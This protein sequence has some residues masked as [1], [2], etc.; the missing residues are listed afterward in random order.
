M[1]FKKSLNQKFFKNW[2]FKMS[3]VL[4]YIIADGCIT[5]SKDRKNNPFTLNI[6]STEKKQLYRIK[7]ALK[8]GHKISKKPTG[9]PGAIGY[10]LQIRNLIL[11]KDLMDLGVFPRKTQNLNYIKV[12]RAYFSDF[13]RGFFDGDGS[14]YIYIVNKVPQIKT[15]FT[16]PSLSFIT[17]L[18][19]ELCKE[20]EIPVKT[21]HEAKDKRRKSPLY[22]I[23]FY[24][25]DCEK[26]AKFMYGSKSTLYLPR[27][28]QVFERWE[29]IKRR[30]YIK[31]NY[32]SRVGWHLNQKVF[33]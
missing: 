1:I 3:Y 26:L 23:N 16:S 18:N 19:T 33:T 6:T 10:Q 5:T 31:Q 7:K 32:P 24:I 20:I 9:K 4:G 22:Y 28:R 27:K 21:V 15:S 29:S 8:S 11:V 12:P 30:H 25:D 14:V 13:V 2:A 17:K